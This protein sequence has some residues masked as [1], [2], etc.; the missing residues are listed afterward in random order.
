MLVLLP[1][2]LCSR[3]RLLSITARAERSGPSRYIG[4]TLSV[5]ARASPLAGDGLRSSPHAHP[6]DVYGR[7]EHRH[8]PSR[9][10]R[11]NSQKTISLGSVGSGQ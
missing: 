6:P 4:F 8:V 9:R 3:R 11:A 10:E 2:T 1:P 5:D 7:R